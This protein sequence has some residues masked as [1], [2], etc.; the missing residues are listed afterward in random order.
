MVMC[1]EKHAG[2]N[3]HGCF[4]AILGINS[5]YFPGLEMFSERHEL[6]VSFLLC[7]KYLLQKLNKRNRFSCGY[8][9]RHATKTN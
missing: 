9:M 6:N 4:W 8:D 5:D 7:F 3:Y 2:L 1:L